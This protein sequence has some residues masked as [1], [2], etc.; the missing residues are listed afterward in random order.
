MADIIYIKHGEIDRVQWDACILDA[1]NS[2]IYAQSSYLDALCQW[3]ALVMGDYEA[4][5][6]LPRRKKMGIGYLYQPAFTQQLGVFSKN[7]VTDETI[8]EFVAAA[9]SR[10]KFAE[11]C[12]NYHN[13]RGTLKKVNL[14]QRV[15]YVLDLGFSYEFIYNNYSS[16]LKKKLSWIKKFECS[17]GPY[18]DFGEMIQLYRNLYGEKMKSV[19]AEDFRR[20]VE[21]CRK[22]NEDQ[23]IICRV[24]KDTE[25]NILAA[26][27]LL[28]DGKRIYNIISCITESGKKVHANDFIYDSLF[29]EFSGKPLLFDFEGSDMRGIADFY[30]KFSPIAQPYPFI[31]WNYL[32]AVLQLIKK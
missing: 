21:L 26:L 4:V 31:K 28:H 2:L 32:P 24:A 10:F 5:M 13:Q 8:S 6:P 27:V 3:D 15:N 20:F 1:A 17:Y 30:M 16:S 29:R 11:I 25:G 7:S 19:S 9:M 14:L 18:K 23:K 12:L 22:L